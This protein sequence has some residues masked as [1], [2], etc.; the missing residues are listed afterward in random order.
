MLFKGAVSIP[1]EIT[2]T[3]SPRE[4]NDACRVQELIRPAEEDM[5]RTFDET[6][7]VTQTIR[8]LTSL[9]GEEKSESSLSYSMEPFGLKQNH[10]PGHTTKH[11]AESSGLNGFTE[12]S[13]LKVGSI[14]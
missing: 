4:E 11:K 7:R 9:I 6:K 3:N 8:K 12:L 10:R 14:D 13:M 2:M 1:I 5:N